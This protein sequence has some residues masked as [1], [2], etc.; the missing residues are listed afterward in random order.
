MRAAFQFGESSIFLAEEM[1]GEAQAI[2]P[3]DRGFAATS[4]SVGQSGG[5]SP[6]QD[7]GD[8]RLL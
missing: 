6:D 7:L 2:K 4:R 5:V 8:K 1:R 3:L